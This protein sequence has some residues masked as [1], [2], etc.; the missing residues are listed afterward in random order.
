[1]FKKYTPPILLALA[2]VLGGWGSSSGASFDLFGDEVN[3]S[4]EQI[5][6]GK[7]TFEGDLTLKGLLDIDDGDDNI[8]L[9][10]NACDS[11]TAGS[12]LHNVCI[13]QDAG[14]AL[15]TGDD[16]V[17]IG[18]DA[19]KVLTTEANNT[20]IGYK[21]GEDLID[22]DNVIIGYLAASNALDARQNVIFG[23]LAVSSG[24]LQ[25]DRNVFIGYQVAN[26]TTSAI[27][28]VVI[29]NTAAGSGVFT[30][31]RNVFVGMDAGKVVTSADENVLIGNDAGKALT[32]GDNNV[33]LGE[34]ACAT[35][36]T[37]SDQLCIDSTNTTTPLIQGN[38][39]TDSLTTNA[40]E[41]LVPSG[42]AVLHAAN[43]TDNWTTQAGGTTSS[44]IDRGAS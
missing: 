40:F 38:F 44:E 28:N 6:T 36:T 5:I 22:P 8:G 14:T 33:F 16:S 21:A 9:G 35:L 20:L 1:M 29:G 26:S 12:G 25:G 24:I 19:G 31:G 39:S 3:L 2:L 30:G 4:G 32:T 42:T 10:T 23:S 11:I 13:G 34:S 37:E 27:D 17:I 15:T 43:I 41:F 7:K 18:V